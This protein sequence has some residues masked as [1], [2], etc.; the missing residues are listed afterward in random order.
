MGKHLFR[1]ENVLATD[2][3]TNTSLSRPKTPASGADLAYREAVLRAIE[4]VLT[5]A[6][7]DAETIEQPVLAYL[8]DMAIAEVKNSENP[9]QQGTRQRRQKRGSN[10]IQFGS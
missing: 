1:P 5:K 2:R 4:R 8:L 9:D 3:V 6:R 7:I 10:V